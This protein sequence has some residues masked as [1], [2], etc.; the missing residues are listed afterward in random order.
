MMIFKTY[1][2]WVGLV[3]SDQ[4]ICRV[5]LPK[6]DKKA[7]E[8]ELRRT[9]SGVRGSDRKKATLPGLE[10]AI[11]LL[12]QYFSGRSVS[13]DLP[14]D[15]SYHTGFRQSV[16]RAAREIPFGETRSYAWIARRIGK[17]NAA[18]AV[19]NALG[20]NPVPIFIP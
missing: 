16:W 3:S 8:R 12:Q 11:K 18:R 5:V 15:L 9:E 2:G 14:F 20:A 10:K 7:V 1:L 17:P 13:F 19:G 4:G 6:K